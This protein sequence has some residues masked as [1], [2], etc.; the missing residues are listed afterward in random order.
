MIIV[1]L[2]GHRERVTLPTP[3]WEG[4]IQT[5]TGITLEA[6]Y[7]GART[8]R[9]FVRSYSIWQRSDGTGRLEGTTYAEI[10]RDEYLNLCDLA[11][12][13][14]LGVDAPEV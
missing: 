11:G 5:G 10:D 1:T 6:I 4:R 8:G 9:M 12:V 7:R 14:P 2:R 13:E 3:L